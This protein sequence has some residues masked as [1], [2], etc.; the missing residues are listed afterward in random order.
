MAFHERLS[1]RSI[2]QRHLSAKTSLSPDEARWLMDVDHVDREAYVVVEGADIW[3]VGRFD[4]LPPSASGDLAAEIAFVVRDDHQ[5]EGWGT[6]LLQAIIE[7][8]RKRG[9]T[10]LLAEVMPG[11]GRMLTVFEHAG[12]PVA[13]D[14]V[15][16]CVQVRLDMRAHATSD[17]G[18][19]PL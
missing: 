7:A 14:H 15:R 13:I 18:R 10:Q 2:Y 5:G 3:G 19:M 4:V 11:N 8:A 16:G 12:V 17:D 9:V 6:R 1:D